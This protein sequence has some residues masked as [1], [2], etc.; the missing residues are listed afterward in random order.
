MFFPDFWK[1]HFLGNDIPTL[2][3]GMTFVTKMDMFYSL[4]PYRQNVGMFYGLKPYRQ[5]VLGI[6]D[7]LW[8]E[9]L[10]AKRWRNY[11]SI[12]VH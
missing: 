8:S 5:N 7:A 11:S 10:Q 3:L 9:A 6:I 2:I 4:K 12:V 1:H